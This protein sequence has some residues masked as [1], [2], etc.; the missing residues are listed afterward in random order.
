MKVLSVCVYV[1]NLLATTAFANPLKLR[2]RN[3]DSYTSN[4]TWESLPPLLNPRQENS[5]TA[6][7]NR[8]YVTGGILSNVS[9]QPNNPPIAESVIFSTISTTTTT[10]YYDVDTATWHDAASMPVSINHG[11]IATVN[12]KIYVLGGLS[13][14]NLSSWNALSNTYVYDSEQ[15]EWSPMAPMPADTARGACA[16]GVHGDEVYLAGGKKH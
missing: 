12:G 7:N 3:F 10:Q 1:F 11:N 14:T 8:I 13:G 4:G 9:Y 16:V 15:D 5:V 2:E 6:L